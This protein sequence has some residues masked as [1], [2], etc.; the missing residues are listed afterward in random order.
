MLEEAQTLL[1]SIVAHGKAREGDSNDAEIDAA[2]DLRDAALAFVRKAAERD[3]TLSEMLDAFDRGADHVWED[4]AI[5]F[6][7]LLAEIHALIDPDFV[8]E[9][10]QAMDL[11]NEQVY[12]L[13]TRAT[14]EFERIKDARV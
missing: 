3:I 5:Q 11:E 4:N 14:A 1:D 7:R 8:T 2:Q 10:A 13:F 6:P 9:I 12:E